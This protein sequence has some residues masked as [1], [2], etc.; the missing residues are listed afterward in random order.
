[1]TTRISV[2]EQLPL[3]FSKPQEVFTY[4]KTPDD[5]VL[6]DDSGLKYFYL[7]RADVERR[8]IDLS[9][10][11]DATKFDAEG[12]KTTYI[13][14]LLEVLV[15]YERRHGRTDAQIV[16]W[17]GC[18]RDIITLN[19]PHC[20]P[21]GAE[22]DM[23]VTGFDGQVFVAHAPKPDKPAGLAPNMSSEEKLKHLNNAKF[24]YTGY[25]FEQVAMLEKPWGE[26]SRDEIEERY[27]DT[28]FHPYSTEYDMLIR[29]KIGDVPLLYACETDGVEGFKPV[30]GDLHRN[31]VELK[32]T[33]TITNRWQAQ[34]F[35]VKLYKT[36]VQSYLSRIPKVVYGFRDPKTMKLVTTEE[37]ATDGM[38]KLI[39][40]S[41]VTPKPQRWSP[42]Q[43]LGFFGVMARFLRDRVE[44][45]KSY[46]LKFDQ[47][48]Q[49]LVL[50]PT[51]IDIGR[52]VSFLTDEFVDW[53]S[54]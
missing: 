35:E 50:A 33:N 17:R 48:T 24:N 44:D 30:D 36:W 45:G 3:P 27:T 1:M 38:P 16:T 19:Q 53:R 34:K 11:F 40:N 54:T 25:K 49:E 10:G 37:F 39:T 31:Y 32:T 42:K 8:P 7:P 15:E 46:S 21:Y 14:S 20:N 2:R 26:C 13:D 28:T 12:G 9:A 41:V 5:K 18:W 4:S 43:T 29:S 6:F 52:K 47:K 23:V 22:L 51:T